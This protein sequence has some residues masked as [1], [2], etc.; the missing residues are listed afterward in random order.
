MVKNKTP[1]K[2]VSKKG[3]EEV[4]SSLGIV[5]YVWKYYRWIY[6]YQT[7]EN[8]ELIVLLFISLDDY[9]LRSA[10]LT[11]LADHNPSL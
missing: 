8:L 10:A 7:I 2:K 5:L 9:F 11:I 3:S 1:Y 6:K 4:L